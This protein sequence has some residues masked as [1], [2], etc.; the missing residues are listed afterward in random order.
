MNFLHRFRNQIWKSKRQT[1]VAISD[2][3]LAQDLADPF[4]YGTRP[5]LMKTYTLTITEQ[6]R[7]IIA[8]ALSQFSQLHLGQTVSDREAAKHLEPRVR[9]LYDYIPNNLAT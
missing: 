9:S 8:A 5:V 2:N 7:D 3:S 4:G 1:R 6:Q